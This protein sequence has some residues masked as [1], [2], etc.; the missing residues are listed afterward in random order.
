MCIRDRL[1][2]IDILR[3]QPARIGELESVKVA[4]EYFCDAVLLAL[5]KRLDEG[6]RKLDKADEILKAIEQRKRDSQPKIYPTLEP[7]VEDVKFGKNEVTQKKPI[8]QS[9]QLSQ[10]LSVHKPA[11]GESLHQ[12]KEGYAAERKERG[13][14]EI[15]EN[16]G[17]YLPLIIEYMNKQKGEYKINQQDSVNDSEIDKENYRLPTVGKTKEG[18]RLSG[19]L[20][21]AQNVMVERGAVRYL[22]EMGFPPQIVT[23]PL[24]YMAMRYMELEG[25]DPFTAVRRAKEELKE[26]K[27]QQEGRE[28]VEWATKYFQKINKKLL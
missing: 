5:E 6:K 13:D 24:V 26:M 11:L 20:K 4:R 15:L 22:M 19:I 1:Q 27:T 9:S 23:N 12:E 21:E 17:I 2:I 25:V 14:E 10:P 3:E 18:S 8:E 16:I 7:K 28:L